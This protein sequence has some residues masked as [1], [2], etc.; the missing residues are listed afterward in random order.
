MENKTIKEQII[1]K[2]QQ[3]R[4]DVRNTSLIDDI[5][6]IVWDNIDDGQFTDN[7]DKAI[8]ISNQ[9]GGIQCSLEIA[10]Q[11]W[12]DGDKDF[13]EPYYKQ[14]FWDMKCLIRYVEE[15]I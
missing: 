15:N 9:L 14:A 13:A 12:N 1:D 6:I 11:Y 5:K 8:Y 7:Y 2:L 4:E 10:E 3:L